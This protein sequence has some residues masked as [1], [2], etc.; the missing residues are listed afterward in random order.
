MK[1]YLPY[2]VV[3]LL[4]IGVEILIVN[5]IVERNNQKTY[6]KLVNYIESKDIKEIDGQEESNSNVIKE[7]TDKEKIEVENNE[8][9]YVNGKLIT[10][11]EEKEKYLN[12]VK[13]KREELEK[14]IKEMQNDI[15]IQMDDMNKRFNEMFESY[16]R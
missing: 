1:K 10:D 3:I 2:A 5:T 4:A 8:K 11:D 12:K 13:N 15:D 16:F 6:E 14:E 9:I 7:E